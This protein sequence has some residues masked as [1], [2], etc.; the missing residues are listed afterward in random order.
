MWYVPELDFCN[1]RVMSNQIKVMHLNMMVQGQS[2]ESCYSEFFDRVG[3]C[4]GTLVGNLV[5]PELAHWKPTGWR[6][7][8]VKSQ[9]IE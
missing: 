5:P 9:N 2:Y 7:F 4:N 8:K 6:Y 1:S 3:R